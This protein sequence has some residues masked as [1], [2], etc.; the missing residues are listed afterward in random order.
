MILK[1]RPAMNLHRR[2]SVLSV[3]VPGDL[4]SGQDHHAALVAFA[5][6]FG[7][8]PRVGGE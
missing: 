4:S 5:F 1:K 8:Y 6:A 3:V 2:A 7:H